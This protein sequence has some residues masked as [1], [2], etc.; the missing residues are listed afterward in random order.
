MYFTDWA[1]RAYVRE[2]HKPEGVTLLTLAYLSD[3]RQR[4]G[5]GRD[6][7][8]ETGQVAQFTGY[9]NEQTREHLQRLRARGLVEHVPSPRR[10]KPGLWRLSEDAR[11][12][13]AAVP[14]TPRAPR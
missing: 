6:W 12:S 5:E 4:G 9:S 10:G 14:R 11:R 8:W 1:M 13:R 2:L 3:L 7:W